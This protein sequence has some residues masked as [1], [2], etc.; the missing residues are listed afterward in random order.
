MITKGLVLSAVNPSGSF[1]IYSETRFKH[2]HEAFLVCPNP[3]GLF[4]GHV[5]QVWAV[6]LVFC[7][8]A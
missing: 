8:A 7:H 6:L 3:V 2:D 4:L 5:E 1:G